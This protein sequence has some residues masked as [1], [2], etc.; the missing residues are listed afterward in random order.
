MFSIDDNKAPGLMGILLRF[1]KRLGRLLVM[2][3]VLL[4]KIFSPLNACSKRIL[5]GL[6]KVVSLNQSAFVPGRRISDNILLVQELMHNY[7]R[8]IESP[9]CAFKVDIQKAY[10]TVDWDF[11]GDILKGYGFHKIMTEWIMNCITSSPFSVSVNGNIFGYFKDELFLFSRGEVDYVKIIMVALNGFKD[12]AGLIP[13]LTRRSLPI[14]LQGVG[15]KMENR[16]T[17]WKAK[18]RSF[19]GRLQLIISVLSAFYVYWALVFILPVS[20]V[21]QLEQKLRSFLLCQ[22]HIV[23][24]KSQSVLEYCLLTE[25]RRWV[26]D[27]S[28]SRC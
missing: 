23:K 1:P 7:H 4:L 22:G 11:L 25:E 10:D 27:S 18:S 20:I 15:G 28:D 17:D 16:I 13:S 2:T 24:G 26:G 14:R 3:F 6:D 19:A 8:D 21:K 5:E 12:M 9:R